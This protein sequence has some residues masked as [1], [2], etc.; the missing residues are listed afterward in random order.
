MKRVLFLVGTALLAG[1]FVLS[2]WQDTHREWT[3]Y[4]QKFL[5]TLAR[6][7]RRGMTVGIKQLILTDLKRVDR[8]MSCHIAIDKPQLE[9]GVEPFK[10]HPGEYLAWH[11][12]ERFG[13]TI[14]H[15]GQGLATEVRAAHGD[16]KHWE[17]PLLRGVLVQASCRQCHGNLEKIAADVPALIKG[18]QLFK[19]QG[20]YACHKIGEFGQ[21]VAPELTDVGSKPYALMKADFEFV[22]GTDDRINWIKQKLANP[23]K[24]NPGFRKEELPP[25]EEE[26][27]PTAMPNFGLSEEAIEALTVYMLSLTDEKLPASYVIPARPEPEPLYASSVEAGRAVF[28]KHG[29]AGC[30]GAGGLGGRKNWNAQLGEEEPSL[31]Y[32]KAYYDRE[33][34]KELIRNGR[35]PVPRLNPARPAPALY[36]PPWKEKIPEEDLEQLVDYLFSLYDQVAQEQQRGQAVSETAP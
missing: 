22:E 10:A 4:Q 13:C 1:L 21:T 6:D 9:L 11:P 25:G 14:C 8:C 33:S 35:Q 34:L 15:G 32:V 20:C 31:V 7:E 3:T 36:M 18:I 19:A 2:Y 24:I 17:E 5:R 30:H 29:C 28:E 27:F 12:P 23:R 26:V 16:V